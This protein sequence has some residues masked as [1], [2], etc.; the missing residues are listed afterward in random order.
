[1]YDFEEEKYF[2]EKVLGDKSTRVKSPIR[3]LKS[4]AIMASGISTLF[5]R[6]KPNEIWDKK[7]ILQ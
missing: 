3:L 4:P 7:L 6:E 2:D 1:M 5:L